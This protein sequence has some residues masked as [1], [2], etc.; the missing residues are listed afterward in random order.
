MFDGER[1]KRLRIEKGFTQQQLGDLINVT[2]VSICC[3]EKNNRTPNIETLMDLSRVLETTP[4]YLLGSE[5]NMRFMED[6]E[7]YNISVSKEDIE[8]IKE[9]KKHYDLYSMLKDNPKR[10]IDKI[11]KNFT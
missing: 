2:K 7:E 6:N 10:I 11:D 5:A 1:L 4:N 3:Y 9:L 8:I